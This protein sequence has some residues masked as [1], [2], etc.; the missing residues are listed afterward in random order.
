MRK[1]WLLGALIILTFQASGEL[2]S[3]IAEECGQDYAEVISI[4]NPGEAYGHPGPVDGENAYDNKLCVQGIIGAEIT[5]QSCDRNAAFHIFSEDGTSHFSTYDVYNLNVC[6]GGMQTTLSETCDPE[7]E[8]ELLSVSGPHNAHVAAPDAGI[9]DTLLCGSY[10]TPENVSVSFEFSLS[11][12]DEVYFDSNDITDEGEYTATPPA[13]FPYLVSVSDSHVSGIVE[14]EFLKVN[15]SIGDGNRLEMVRDHHDAHFMLP[16]TE[17]DQTTIE[18]R[19]D[20]IVEGDFLQQL[21]PNFGFYM[22]DSPLLRVILQPD[23][24]VKSELSIGT[25]PSTIAVRKTG[26]DEITLTAQ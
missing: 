22:P 12:S 9:Y 11:G 7:N 23:I 10:E 19:R 20:M 15:R 14:S 18:G 5:S 24:N 25:S 21:S 2:D 8:T 1:I 16:F 3:M 17:G 26:E 13:D 4:S 6:T